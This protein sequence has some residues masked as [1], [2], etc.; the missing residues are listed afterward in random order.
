VKRIV[1]KAED[2]T[3]CRVCESMCAFYHDGV[4]N[5]NLARIYVVNL[6]KYEEKPKITVCQQCKEAECVEVCPTNALEYD[7]K[8]KFVVFN[9]DNCIGCNAC[10][11]AC[12]FSAITRHPEKNVILKCDLCNGTPQCV[13]HCTANALKLEEISD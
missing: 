5:P 11:E 2:C 7:Q 10:V 6:G 13:A 9:S 12:P 3:G 4:V 8:K 1:W